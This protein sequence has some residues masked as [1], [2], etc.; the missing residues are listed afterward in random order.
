[1][2]GP[3]DTEADAIAAGWRTEAGNAWEAFS[4]ALAERRFEDARVAAHSLHVALQNGAPCPFGMR[5]H[6]PG[7][8][9]DELIMWMGAYR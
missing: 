1:M 9:R 6:N 8:S 4:M 5:Q 2:T 7:K 3:F